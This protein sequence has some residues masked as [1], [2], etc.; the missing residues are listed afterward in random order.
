M[1]A[2]PFIKELLE[3]IARI[4]ERRAACPDLYGFELA[5]DRG[6]IT[7]DEFDAAK[8]EFDRCQR[9]IE[10]ETTGL[11]ALAARHGAAFD[12]FLT[13]SVAQLRRILDLLNR[14]GIADAFPQRFSRALI[15]DLIAGLEA[16]RN[17]QPERHAFAWLLCATV[18]VLREAGALAVTPEA[19]A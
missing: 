19:N 18:D 4:C 2:T 16:R 6:N 8:A 3:R 15:P 7:T 13:E 11:E 12:A 10:E 17:R 9:L 14:G 5:F 1:E